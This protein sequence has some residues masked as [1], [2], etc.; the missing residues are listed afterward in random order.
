MCVCVC[1]C[2]CLCAVCGV[3]VSSCPPLPLPSRYACKGTR[4]VVRPVCDD[5]IAYP[6]GCLVVLATL[7]TGAQIYTPALKAA[8]SALAPSPARP[9]LVA[10]TYGLSSVCVC[11]CV[12][13]CKRE[14]NG[15]RC[16]CVCDCFPLR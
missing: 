6:A 10:G 5:V 2:V 13:V 4:G 15:E 16:G 14:R 11:V 3:C 1:V 12:C 9:A 8:V 7:S